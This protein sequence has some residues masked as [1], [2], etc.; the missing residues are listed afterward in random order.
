MGGSFNLFL[1]VGF[2][3][4]VKKKQKEEEMAIRLVGAGPL[5]AGLRR[6]D[7]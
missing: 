1:T 7:Q 3:P 5:G 6:G 4:E 2:R